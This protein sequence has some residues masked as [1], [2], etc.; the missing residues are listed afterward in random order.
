[1]ADILHDLPIKAPPETV[2]R[3]VSTPEGLDRLGGGEV[4]Y[5]RRLDV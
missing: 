2:F 4:P 3:V 1:M 5:D